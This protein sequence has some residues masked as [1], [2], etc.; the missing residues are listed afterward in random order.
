MEC[1]VCGVRCAVCGGLWDEVLS[2]EF[3]WIC[4]QLVIFFVSRVL[5]A[6]LHD[7]GRFVLGVDFI[8]RSSKGHAVNSSLISSSVS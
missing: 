2:T 3:Y 5:P 4:F 6:D 7:E 8:S 1:G